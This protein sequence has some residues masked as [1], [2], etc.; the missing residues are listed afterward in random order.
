[1]MA[2]TVLLALVFTAVEPQ[3]LQTPDPN[4]IEEVRGTGNRRVPSDTIK[5]NLQTKPNDRFNPNVIRR[6]IKTFDAL[7]HFHNIRV[8][9]DQGK[10]GKIGEYRVTRKNLI[11]MAKHEGWKPA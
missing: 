3:A 10:T 1:M 7:G 9:E 4:R 11:R 6:D 8:E 2:V 5:Y